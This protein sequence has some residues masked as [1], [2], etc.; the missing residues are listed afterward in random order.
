MRGL[1][2]ACLGGERARGEGAARADLFFTNFILPLTYRWQTIRTRTK[3][4]ATMYMTMMMMQM[5]SAS[6][7][8]YPERS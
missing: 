6:A 2:V 4:K 8:V 3:M 7:V 1:G 5:M